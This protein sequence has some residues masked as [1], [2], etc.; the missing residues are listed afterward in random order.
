MI[1]GNVRYL[2]F[3]M[4][5]A[6]TKCSCTMTTFQHHTPDCAKEDIVILNRH[7]AFTLIPA[8]PKFLPLQQTQRHNGACFQTPFASGQRAISRIQRSLEAVTDRDKQKAKLKILQ[9]QV[10]PGYWSYRIRKTLM[11]L[12]KS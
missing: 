1:T 3:S 11:G 9:K 10:S 5:R 6:G 12:E 7:G 2:T 4:R 8:T